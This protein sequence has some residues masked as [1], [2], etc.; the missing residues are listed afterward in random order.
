MET[1]K[2]NK[3]TLKKLSKVEILNDIMSKIDEG[4]TPVGNLDT[5]R[6]DVTPDQDISEDNPFPLQ[7]QFSNEYTQI[8]YKPTVPPTVTPMRPRLG[9][10]GS[11]KSKSKSKSKSKTKKHNK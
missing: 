4:Y 3:I 10:G 2:G 5:V 9:G 7:Q 6:K 11:Y 8:M 1:G